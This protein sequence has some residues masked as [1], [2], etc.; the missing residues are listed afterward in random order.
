[1]YNV[2]DDNFVFVSHF[3]DDPDTSH[4]RDSTVNA[5][6][7]TKKSPGEP[8][9]TTAGMIGDAQDFGIND[10][11]SVPSMGNIG[12]S[13]VSFWVNEKT[14]NLWAYLLDAR[15][16]TGIGYIYWNN[17]TK[18][19]TASSGTIYVDGVVSS[20]LNDNEPHYVTVSG[21]TLN[22]PTDVK[23]GAKNNLAG[24]EFHQGILDEV[25]ISAGGRVAA[26]I[27]A[28]YESG[29]DHLNDYGS[30]ELFPFSAGYIPQQA[31]KTLI[32]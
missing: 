10:Y 16:G 13:T 14:T 20:I 21:I 1:M 17:N 30:E 2:W 4:I 12:V 11:I 3:R 5:N 7:G 26:W 25:R 24:G 9:V 19:L 29:R 32:E 18:S 28:S 15:T 23:F 6:D 22:M 8:A 31:I 27:K